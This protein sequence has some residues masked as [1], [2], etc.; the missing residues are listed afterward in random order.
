[1]EEAGWVADGLRKERTIGVDDG[2]TVI[3]G[4]GLAVTCAIVGA[5]VAV[6]VSEPSAQAWDASS[7]RP[8]TTTHCL[9]PRRPERTGPGRSP[10]CSECGAEYAGGLYTSR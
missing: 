5:G 10:L 7:M 4:D 8:A 6:E 2:L 3:S 9:K 1:M